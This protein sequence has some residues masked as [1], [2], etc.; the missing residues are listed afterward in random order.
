MKHKYGLSPIQQLILAI[1]ELYDLFLGGGRGG[2]KS[3]ALAWL[4]IRHIELYGA[5]ARILYLRRSYPGIADF[6]SICRE[7]FIQM[8]GKGARYNASNHTWRFPNGAYM[9][10]GQLENE[11]DYPKYQGR[12]FNLL[13]VDEAGQYATPELLDRLR[14]NL[15]GPK[16]MP[17]RMVMAAN[18]G[19][20]GH[21]WLAQRYVF[22]G[23]P[24]EPFY[25][26]KSK[27]QWVHAPS[28]FLDNPFIDQEAYKSQLESSC[29]TDPELLRAWLE[30]DWAV[31]RGAFFAQVIDE[32]RNAVDPWKQL[33]GENISLSHLL[34]AKRAALS[35]QRWDFFLAHDFGTSAP[36][37]TY[38]CAKSPGAEGPDG[39]W[40]PR[41]SIILVDELATAVPGQLNQGLGYTVPHL[42]EEIIRMTQ[43]WGMRR[44]EGVADDACFSNH[45][46]GA[47]SIAD[48]FKRCGV[49]FRPAQKGGRVYGWEVMRRML[50]DAGK[51]D[52]P[53]LYISRSCEYFWATVPYLARNPRNIQDLDSRGPDHGA[54]AC[55]YGL[56]YNRPV[57][58]EVKLIGF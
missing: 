13:L 46:H 25:E 44:A 33:P 15:R 51:P 5:N 22:K 23:N 1:P 17:V 30:G 58:K 38:V 45:G 42:S 50:Q 19:D 55:R 43:R 41:D 54:D 20:V 7:L 9:E 47:G 35:S 34:P 40:Y 11:S 32:T 10:L 27:R 53:G 3:W 24:W 36:S 48:E 57:C 39:R 18:P 31:A 16:D 14:S 21:H 56:I 4:A 28:T 29:P 12:S 37:V 8:F 26:E 52:V 49:Y 6:E 2:A